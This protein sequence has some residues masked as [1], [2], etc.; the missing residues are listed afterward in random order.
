MYRKEKRYNRF[1]GSRKI[2]DDLFNFGLCFFRTYAR[3]R[4]SSFIKKRRGAQNFQ[5]FASLLSIC[6]LVILEDLTIYDATFKKKFEK[7]T[8]STRL[9]GDQFIECTNI[10]FDNM[11]REG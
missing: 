4:S 3:G 7:R 2:D 5:F 1:L 10:F 6:G 11:V 9:N 8:R